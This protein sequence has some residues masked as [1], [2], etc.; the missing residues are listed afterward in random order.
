MVF[1]YNCWCFIPSQPVWLSEGD[2]KVGQF[3]SWLLNVP[4]TS[5]CISGMDLLRQLYVLPH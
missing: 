2:G 4:A 1:V 3:V 5:Q